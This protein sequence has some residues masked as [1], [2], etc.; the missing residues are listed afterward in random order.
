MQF[1]PSGLETH[2]VVE[3]LLSGDNFHFGNPFVKWQDLFL[4][5]FTVW[6]QSSVFRMCVVDLIAFACAH[7]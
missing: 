6:T 2:Q 1:L 4:N 5:I 3:E 7:T